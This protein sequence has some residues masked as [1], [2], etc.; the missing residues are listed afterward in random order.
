MKSKFLF[1]FL[2]LSL[3]IVHDLWGK[4]NPDTVKI[5]CYVISL[6]NFNFKDKEYNARFWLWMVYENPEI[7]FDNNIEIPN[8][9]SFSIDEIIEDSL[10]QNGKKYK[11]VQMKINCTMKQSW[12]ISGYPFDIQDLNILVESTKYDSRDLTFVADT[13]GRSY[14]PDLIVDG[15]NIRQFDVK[16]GSSLYATTFGEQT[17]NNK[18][19]NYANFQMRFALERTAWGLFFKLFLGM[20]VAFAIAYVSFYINPRVSDP[21]FGLPVGGLFSAVGN[22]YIVDSYLPDTSQLT[23]VDWLH[24]LTF[25]MILA[26]II[27]SAYALK[28]EQQRRAYRKTDR[29]AKTIVIAFYFLVN[30]IFILIAYWSN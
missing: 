21:R 14:D 19:V 2:F 25:V 30:M 17:L 27:F 12:E 10:V 7:R 29:I 22:K 23:I 3:Y 13:M 1:F 26:I 5:G 16:T 28:L 18:E 15:W 24:G 8:A 9:K 4:S 20:Y 11:W 6:H